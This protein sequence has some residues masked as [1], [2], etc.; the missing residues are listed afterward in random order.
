MVDADAADAIQVEWEVRR[1]EAWLDDEEAQ[2]AA[3]M[4]RL[5]RAEAVMRAE[6]RRAIFELMK[7]QGEI[8]EFTKR[9]QLAIER[10]RR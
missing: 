8:D 3:R 7:L 9:Q 5:M 6:S 10:S 4:R 2:H 1:I